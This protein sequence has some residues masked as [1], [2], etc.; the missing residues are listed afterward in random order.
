MA[1]ELVT[2]IVYMP[3]KPG[4]DFKSISTPEGKAWLAALDIMKRQEG[5]LQSRCGRQ[6]ENPD[7]LMWFID[8]TSYPT[9]RK[10]ITSPSYTPFLENIGALVAGAPYFYHFSPAPSPTTLST[11]PCTEFAVFYQT[12]P[13]FLADNA[14]KFAAALD[15]AEPRPDGYLGS[16]AG[17]VMEE[18]AKGG[19]EEGKGS[20]VVLCLGWTSRDAHLRFR[21]ESVVFRDN[22]WLLREGTKG[23][24][25]VHVG[26][27]DV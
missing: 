23:A 18:I 2:E 10:F 17:G 9:H 8:W 12:V 26:F 3:L 15:S 20:A 25:V 19:A 16:V 5:Y 14:R 7:M 1:S 21:N 4:I 13:T 22:I 27:E 24:E 6:F 11:F